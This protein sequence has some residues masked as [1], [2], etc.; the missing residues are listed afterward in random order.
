MTDLLDRISI[1]QPCDESWEEMT[2]NSE[3]RFC[4]HCS[5]HVHNL[6][7]MTREQ[8]VDLVRRA[9]G[10]L[11]VRYIRSSAAVDVLPPVTQISRSLTRV[12]AVLAGT[13]AMASF[14][15]AQ[16]PTTDPPR[17]VISPRRS[18]PKPKVGSTAIVSGVIRDINEAV[19]P[20]VSVKL[21]NKDS[22]WWCIEVSDSSGEFVFRNVQIGNYVLEIEA[23][24]F[25]R[26]VVE[27]LRV[28]NDLRLEK[29]LTVGEFFETMGIVGTTITGADFFDVP[30]SKLAPLDRPVEPLY[31]LQPQVKVTTT[32][33]KKKK[34]LPK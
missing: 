3:V 6:S 11:C 10:Q 28:E 23:Y 17:T 14:A 21:Q 13:L 18:D 33:T 4:S 19:I 9:N 26:L 2:G 1:K 7:S 31:T 25:E 15:P 30:L 12:A 27:N 5:K 20:N 34:N 32:K 8:A 24:G 29:V 16:T 22:E